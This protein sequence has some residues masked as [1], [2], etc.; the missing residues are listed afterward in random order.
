MR[1]EHADFRDGCWI[2]LG[3]GAGRTVAQNGAMHSRKLQTE[4]R[5]LAVAMAAT[6][7]SGAS[8]AQ[9]AGEGAPE[10][11]LETVTVYAR[12]LVPIAQVAATVTVIPR[13]TIDRTLVTDIR[14]LVRY[15]PGLT[16]RNDPFRF[17]L[18][19]ISVR[20]VGGNRVA[21][22]VDGIPAAGGFAIG[23]FGDSGRSF[24][25]PAFIERV[26]VLR[27]PASSL[28]GSDAIGGV[29]A[30]TTTTPRD[31]LGGDRTR[32]LRS[33]GGYS[34]A[35]AGWHAV[36]VGA[37]EA[38][39]ARLL[40]G[41]AHRVGNEL[42]SAAD[43]TPN[44][45]DYASDALLAKVEWLDTPGGPLTLAGEASL[46]DQ[47][48]SI[49][50][51]LGLQGTRFVNSTLLEG[52]DRAERYRLS[53]SQKLA[54]RAAFGSADWRVYAQGTDTRQDTLEQR[55]AVPPRTPPVQ[56]AR[57]FELEDRTLGAEFTAIRDFGGTSRIHTVVYGV[58]L[59]QSRLEER[60]DGQQTDLSSGNSSSVILGESFPLRDFPVSDVMR[61]GAFVQDELKFGDSGWT[62][63]PALRADYYEL[64]PQPDRLYREDNPNAIAV[65]VEDFSLAP[66]LGVT[67]SF[68][69]GL[70]LFLQYARGFRAPPPE[71][72]NIGLDL[73]LFN[74]RAIPNPDLEPE[75]SDGYELGLRW[76]APGLALTASLHYTDY[77]D[78]IE[79]KVNLGPDPDSGVTLF[80]SQNI[81]EARI[82]GA[83]LVLDWRVGDRAPALEGWTTRLAAAWTRGED[84]VSDEPL[85]SVDPASAVLSLRYEAPAGRWGS[86]LVTTAVASQSEV[87]DSRVDLYETGGY[88]TLD[89]LGHYDFGRGLRINAG[90]FNLADA[91]YIEWSDVRGRVVGDPLIPYYT[92]PGRNVSVTLHWR[93]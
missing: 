58:E 55:R 84:R 81:A 33:E 46:I 90:V 62:L 65:G 48:T 67:R 5:C 24:V 27:G 61:A 41:Y 12:R 38:G 60:R 32:G 93:L 77:E 78:F 89:L 20:G 57:R 86:E 45:R 14:D 4:I 13:E 66:K 88:V 50:A 18:D 74:V 9:D 59:A 7:A 21:V 71:D 39:V 40:F 31:L 51:F 56:I 26:E 15:E 30:M 76:N 2:D 8:L 1:S 82:Y 6:A 68:E 73:P 83:E 11:G 10:A 79:S 17:G 42:D 22:E 70:G 35:D 72:V 69:N 25:D 53:A 85:N 19:S 44:P 52:D 3:H 37:A 63:I 29:V 91:E 43:V 75:T 34:G 16:V 47:Q 64:E 49:D 54:P 36:A 87:D 80:Q 28:Y 92:R 23:S